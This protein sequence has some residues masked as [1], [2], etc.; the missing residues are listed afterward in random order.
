LIKRLC[1]IALVQLAG[2]SVACGATSANAAPTDKLPPLAIATRDTFDLFDVPAGVDPGTAVLNK[3]QISAT[4][5]GEKL[6][7]KGWLVHAQIIG[8]DGQSLSRRLADIQTA[9]NIEAEPVT[10]LFEAYL[11]KMWERG[12]DSLALRF[13]LIDLNSQFDSVDPA[14]LMLNSSHGIGPDLSRSGRNPSS[15]LLG[16]AVEA[17]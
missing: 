17:E 7:L 8:F 13:G 16:G 6:G 12:D 1:R 2:L 10:R 14:S 15:R 5:R 9:D 11:S 3:L 4:L